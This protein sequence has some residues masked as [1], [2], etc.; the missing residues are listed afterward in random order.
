LDVDKAP[1]V[2]KRFNIQ[3]IP[4][5]IVFKDGKPHRQ[6]VGLTKADTLISAITAAVD[7]K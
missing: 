4:T 1:S 6:F 3:A 2:A 5:L 7:S